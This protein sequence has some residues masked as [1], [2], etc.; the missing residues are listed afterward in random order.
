M[1]AERDF[2]DRQG[3]KWPAVL[4]E[5]WETS[6]SF[7]VLSNDDRKAAAALGRAALRFYDIDEFGRE[8]PRGQREA[9]EQ[10]ATT[11]DIPYTPNYISDVYVTPRGPMVWTDTKGDLPR[12]MGDAM[13]RVLLD[14]LRVEGITAHVVR[15]PVDVSLEGLP[16]IPLSG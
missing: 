11:W 10:A 1:T 6:P 12:A 5:G 2:F 9:E 15:A 16:V 8:L 13:L 7:L 4:G 14:E 3:A